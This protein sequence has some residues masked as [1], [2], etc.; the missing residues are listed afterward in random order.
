VK[1]P[2][3]IILIVVI[4]ILGLIS[5]RMYASIPNAPK[6]QTWTP[7]CVASV[8]RSWGTFKGASTQSGLAFED[9]AGTLRFLTNI[10]CDGSPVVALEIRRIPG[11]LPNGGNQ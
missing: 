7:G 1:K 10:P 6:P 9:S 2:I 5:F 4:V 3:Q 8:P 11:S